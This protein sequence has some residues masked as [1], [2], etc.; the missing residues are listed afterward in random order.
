MYRSEAGEI[1]SIRVDYINS[2]AV[3]LSYS[4]IKEVLVGNAIGVEASG[5]K[6]IKFL[7]L[8]K[9]LIDGGK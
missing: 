4:D 3:A 2:S 7:G 8:S 1:I 6:D 9:I 5:V